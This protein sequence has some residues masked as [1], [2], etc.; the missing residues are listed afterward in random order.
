MPSKLLFKIILLFTFLIVGH[1]LFSLNT[2]GET[3]FNQGKYDQALAAYKEELKVSP[4]DKEVIYKIGRCL[5]ALN[6]YGDALPYFK[7]ASSKGYI[8]A[9]YFLGICDYW[10]YNFQESIDYFTKY[11]NENSDLMAYEA[12]TI[13]ETIGKDKEA[14]TMLQNVADVSFVDSLKLPKSNFLKFY[15]LSRDLGEIKSCSVFFNDSLFADY[16]GFMTGR[17]DRIIF[18]QDIDNVGH[19][20]ITNKLIDGWSQ[21]VLLS[22]NLNSNRG[23]NYPYL[24]PDGVTIYFASKGFNSLGGYDIF[25]SRY[26]SNLNDYTTPVNVG[27]PFNSPYND[28]MMVIDDVHNVGWFATDRY[29]N[30]DSVMVYQF[31]PNKERKVLQFNNQMLLLD[32]SRL[33]MRNMAPADNIE[34]LKNLTPKETEPV[35]PS[36]TLNEMNFVINDDVVYHSVD[37]FINRNALNHYQ[38]AQSINQKIISLKKNIE[39][40]RLE[41]LKNADDSN[42]NALKQT[43]ISLEK[44]IIIQNNTY[45]QELSLARDI[46]SQ[47]L[48][49]INK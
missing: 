27:M 38:L 2:I 32:Y 7:Y 15:K 6:R 39:A 29:Q 42:D 17:K 37:Q 48:E 33:F 34:K 9:D 26:N 13:G 16:Y 30:K 5:Y 19:L 21:A 8:K 45:E 36:D 24:M 14:L 18:S 35:E 3:Y 44:Q 41:L 22:N 25:M 40:D 12:Q 49:K 28:Y 20:M 1:S 46:E 4:N 23:E 43:I 10:L 31:I 47:T 11:Q